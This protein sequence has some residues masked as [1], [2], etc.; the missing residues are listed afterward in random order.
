[1]IDSLNA[2]QTCYQCRYFIKEG[3]RKDPFFGPIKV[4]EYCSK[5][6]KLIVDPW[7]EGEN[8]KAFLRKLFGSSIK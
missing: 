8:C 5:K 6:Q 2:G 3:E 1:M 4:I 7:E